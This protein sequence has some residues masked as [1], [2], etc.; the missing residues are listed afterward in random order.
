MAVSLP[1]GV[2]FA[3]ATTYA[4]AITVTGITNANPGVATA[5]AHGLANGDPLE[6]TSGWSA[7]N[8][9]VVRAASQATNTFALEGIDTSSTTVYPA[10][11]GAGSVRKV[12]AWTDI[13]QVLESTANGGDMQFTTYSFYENDFEV[14]IP[15]QF[16]PQSLNLQIADDPSLPGYIALKAANEARAQRA[17]RMTM[18]SGS[19]FYMKAY[20]SFNETPIMTKNQ[21]M[22]VRATFSLMSRLVRYAS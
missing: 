6:V 16:S 5:T 7:L 22:A 4:S 9:R 15:T 18:P 19:V 8:D 14:Q 11:G 13:T 21:V 3:L 20:I 2:K 10:S 17:V 12:T 1:N